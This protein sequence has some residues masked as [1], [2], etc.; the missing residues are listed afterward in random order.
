VTTTY[1]V[2]QLRRDEGEPWQVASRH[3]TYDEAVLAHH[4]RST[5]SMWRLVKRTEEVVEP[6]AEAKKIKVP[7]FNPQAVQEQYL[8]SPIE[9]MNALIA[10]FNSVTG[11]SIA[12]VHAGEM[13]DFSVLRVLMGMV[14]AIT[15]VLE[16]AELPPATA[17]DPGYWQEG[18]Q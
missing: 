12:P 1:Y 3:D 17:T 4:Q 18:K 5:P 14:E 11:A 10:N 9:K 2:W 7:E 13:V 16:Q 8:A 6:P 15:K